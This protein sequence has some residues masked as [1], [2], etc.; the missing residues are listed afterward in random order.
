M[1]LYLLFI[2][3]EFFSRS[4]NEDK[5]KLTEKIENLAVGIAFF[6]Y[7]INNF[8]TFFLSPRE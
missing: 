8:I 3:G 5:S 6:L 4:N 7:K 2:L 1:E